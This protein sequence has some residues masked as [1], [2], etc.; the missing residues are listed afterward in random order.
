MLLLLFSLIQSQQSPR[1]SPFVIAV[2]VL[3]FI[4]GVSLLVYFFRRIKTSEKEAEEDWSLSRRSLFVNPEPGEQGAE[5]VR[6]AEHGQPVATN[7]AATRELTAIR[8]GE[9]HESMNQQ[10]AQEPRPTQELQ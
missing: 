3:A 6:G 4:I 2:A 7:Q 10:A 1:L 5:Q 9:I 8:T